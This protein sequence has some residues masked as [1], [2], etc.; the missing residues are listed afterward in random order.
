MKILNMNPTAHRSRLSPHRIRRKKMAI[1]LCGVVLYFL[2]CMA[3]LLIPG[4]IFEDL[5]ALGLDAEKISATGAVFMYA[6]AVSQLLAG[7]FSNRYGGVRILLTGGSMFALGTILFPV[8]AHYG[9]ML[10][11]RILTGFGAG[12]VFLGVVK[13]L[14]DLFSRKFAMALGVVMLCSYFGPVCGTVPMVKL[15]DLLR[16]QWAMAAPGIAAALAV[17]VIL[18]L[19]KGTIRKVARGNALDAF[20]LMLK[21]PR[22][23]LVSFSASMIFGIYYVIS[24]QIGPKS[25]MDRCGL[26]PERAALI[27]MLLTVIVALNNV[28]VNLLLKLCGNRRK[29]VVLFS[30]GS[31]LAGTCMGIGAFGFSGEISAVV[32]SF[33]LIAVPAGFFPLFSTIVKE[34]NPPESVG[35]AV[36]VLNFWCFV[37]IAGFQNICGTILHAF[38]ADAGVYS[39]LAYSRVFL[40][41]AAAALAGLT[42]AVFYP[43]T[44]RNTQKIPGARD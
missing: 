11:C 29:P 28:L 13:L 39:P 16:W 7:L 44:G 23:Y 20:Q 22:M 25:M 4:I 2:T 17:L 37:F 21:N 32:L 12:T 35:L 9:L 30:F 8:T 36:A 1:L 42:A 27:I 33:V 10:L 24:S 34:I 14:N 43:E 18:A 31:A 6:Y 26:T 5:Q 19:M 41:L 3:K 38:P 15:V 40:F